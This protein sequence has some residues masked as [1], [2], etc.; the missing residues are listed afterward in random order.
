MIAYIFWTCCISLTYPPPHHARICHLSSSHA[1]CTVLLALWSAVV[2]L[3]SMLLVY[4]TILMTLISW[5]YYTRGI[6][7]FRLPNG[8]PDAP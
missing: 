5:I 2:S 4:M 6:I 3:D 8:S 7:T 1:V